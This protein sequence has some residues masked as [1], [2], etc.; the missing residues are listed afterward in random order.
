MT[1]N[2]V[3]RFQ[4]EIILKSSNVPG[5]LLD[6]W[7]F[8]VRNYG[9]HEF[10]SSR[11]CGGNIPPGRLKRLINLYIG[12]NR[13]KYRSRWSIDKS[14]LESFRKSRH[15]PDGRT[16]QKK[17]QLS[18]HDRMIMK[19]GYVLNLLFETRPPTIM[20]ASPEIRAQCIQAI[21]QL[22]FIE[23]GHCYFLCIGGGFRLYHNK[24]TIH[25]CEFESCTEKYFVPHDTCLITGQ[26]LHLEKQ[27]TKSGKKLQSIVKNSVQGLLGIL[28]CGLCISEKNLPQPSIRSFKG[29]SSGDSVSCDKQC[30]TCRFPSC[31]KEV[32]SN[33]LFTYCYDHIS[34]LF[35]EYTEILEI[36]TAP[37][38]SHHDLNIVKLLEVLFGND[39][40]PIITKL[41]ACPNMTIMRNFC[42]A[43]EIADAQCAGENLSCMCYICGGPCSVYD[44]IAQPPK[45][46]SIVTRK[47][48][49]DKFKPSKFSEFQIK[50]KTYIEE[51]RV[52]TSTASF[53][54]HES[55][56]HEP[57][58]FVIYDSVGIVR[59]S[60]IFGS[61]SIAEQRE[62]FNTRACT[63]VGDEIITALSS[64]NPNMKFAPKTGF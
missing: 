32:L 26:R 20:N 18:W 4:I 13:N 40:T 6:A 31:R 24:S 50:L 9:S 55:V 12:V 57:R 2:F 8:V 35:Q 36:E 47:F 29:K 49:F 14:N 3:T 42:G 51:G 16:A 39:I 7:N 62:H 44:Y 56:P 10:G 1:T 54:M 22:K 60:D 41:M 33:K 38:A 53:S 46:Y 15:C 19:K 25:L 43:C 37:W 59:P 23:K 64:A 11:V 45:D 5:E 21:N 63:V 61:S 48:E 30:Y 27:R 28:Y 17:K 52:I 58:P 34:N